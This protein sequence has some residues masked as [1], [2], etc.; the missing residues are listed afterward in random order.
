LLARATH[1]IRVEREQ[2]ALV[3]LCVPDESRNFGVVEQCVGENLRWREAVRWSVATCVKTYRRHLL[4]FSDTLGRS[5]DL[6]KMAC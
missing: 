5:I 2:S 1:G 6:L 3:W 4:E